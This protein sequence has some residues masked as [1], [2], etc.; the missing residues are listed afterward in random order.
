MRK[1]SWKFA[2]RNRLQPLLHQDVLLFGG[3]GGGGGEEVLL[4]FLYNKRALIHLVSKYLLCRQHIQRRVDSS[5]TT[6]GMLRKKW[7]PDFLIL[8]CSRFFFP[9]FVN[10]STFF[11]FE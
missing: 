8:L 10:L 11:L 9:F 7:A 3:L 1:H 5:A 6:V 2:C 4:K